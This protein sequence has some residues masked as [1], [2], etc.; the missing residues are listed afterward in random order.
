MSRCVGSGL[1]RVAVRVSIADRGDPCR[2]H[3]GEWSGVSWG[4]QHAQGSKRGR[5]A[6]SGLVANQSLPATFLPVGHPGNL[7]FPEWDSGPG[8]LVR[9]SRTKAMATTGKPLGPLRTSSPQFPSESPAPASWVPLW[10]K[11]SL[12]VESDKLKVFVSQTLS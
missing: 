4:T 12:G 10:N 3:P 11:P 2:V 7:S 5:L 1:E 8:L 9:H 6:S